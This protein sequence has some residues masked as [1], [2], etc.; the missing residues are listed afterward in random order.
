MKGDIAVAGFMLTA[1]DWQ[2][3]DAA[4]R[5]ELVA[6]ITQRDR[7]RLARGSGPI[8]VAPDP[9]EAAELAPEIEL[10]TELDDELEDA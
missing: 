7:P 2:E 8:A 10:V 3:L 9:G 5:A 6:V 1:E 4:S